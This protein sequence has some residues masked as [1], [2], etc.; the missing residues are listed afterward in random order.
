MAVGVV[1]LA[2]LA[3]AQ[4]AP[5]E[6]MP[7]AVV[8]VNV[9]AVA[10]AGAGSFI[11]V[12]SVDVEFSAAIPDRAGLKK[13]L[14]EV[15]GEPVALAQVGDEIVAI[16]GGGKG[17]YKKVRVSLND[18]KGLPT[19]RF[20]SSAIESIIRQIN[21]RLGRGS[22]A[23]FYL[24]SG[25]ENSGPA[26]QGTDTRPGGMSL[27]LVVV[28]E[29]AKGDATG[30]VLR[31]SGFSARYVGRA[32]ERTAS[33][34][35]LDDLASQ[36][37]ELAKTIVGGRAVFTSATVRDTSGKVVPRADMAPSDVVKVPLK[38][39]G[40]QLDGLFT[41]GG[42]RSLSEQIVGYLNS[43]GISGVYVEPEAADV[44][45]AEDSAKGSDAS[46]VAALGLNIHTAIVTQIRV[47]EVGRD[48]SPT[49]RPAATQAASPIT[50][51]S[52]IGPGGPGGQGDVLRKDQLDDY[53]ARLNRQPGQQVDAAVTSANEPDSVIL[54]YMVRR[55]APWQVYAQVSNTGTKETNEWRE[56][57]GV[58]GTGVIQR[59]DQLT[60]DLSTAGFD[61]ESSVAGAYDMPLFG[62]GTR[63]RI[64]GQWESFDASQFGQ[65]DM[66]YKGDSYLIGDE[67]VQNVYQHHKLFLDAVVGARYEHFH[68]NNQA[69]ALEGNG[70]FVLPYAGLRLDRTTAESSILADMT[71]LGSLTNADQAQRDALGRLNSNQDTVMLQGNAYAS[72]FLEP[73]LDPGG[74]EA[75]MSTLAHE[76]AFSA[77]GQ[78]AFNQRLIAEEQYVA[79]GLYTVR[80]YPESIVAG[81]SAIVGT[82][83]YRYHVPRGFATQNE[84]GRFM[85]GPFR[86]APQQPYG[87]PD[88]DLILKAFV[89]AGHT[90]NSNIEPYESDAT[91]VGTGVG[92][93][94][95][96]KQNVSVRVDWGVALD[97]VK[98]A[99]GTTLVEA[100]S[101]RVN[102]VFTFKY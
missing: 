6:N 88:W 4:S 78:Y 36:K 98:S 64:Y 76:L 94:L 57:L 91:L 33:L 53:V 58:I 77:H 2:G 100:G 39:L 79:G 92:A 47:I 40:Q 84:P 38:E 11:T 66:K 3:G 96:I 95:L 70:D 99:A 16:P 19:H 61:S 102:F 52:P 54:D 55:D 35:P 89:D 86:W 50:R 5:A 34:P 90:I 23:G 80:G 75:G 32:A 13:A 1:G 9:A 21:D 48:G 25:E 8:P 85:G 87:R 59:G 42:V 7:A 17:D 43:K 63:N 28:N 83:E 49:T 69:A 14:N 12:E 67:V 93:E 71:V 60:L 101:S 56:R 68:V 62:L 18:L 27:H 51:N 81:D 15:L 97:G 26:T 10:T 73:M 45:A 82:M 29:L 46:K 72:F 31:V 20:G 37:F 22:L 65:A 44:K 24:V 41:A 74:Y 30:P